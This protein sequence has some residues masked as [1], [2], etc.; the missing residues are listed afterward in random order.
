MNI[1]DIQ[2]KVPNFQQF[3][4]GW[5]TRVQFMAQ[6]RNFSLSYHIQAGSEAHPVFCPV[7]NGV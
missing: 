5:K 7:D 4:R 2:F 1:H 3:I 6:A